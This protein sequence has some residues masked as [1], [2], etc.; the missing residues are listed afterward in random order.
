MRDFIIPL[1]IGLAILASA[2]DTACADPPR[3]PSVTCTGGGLREHPKFTQTSPGGAEYNFS[4][5][6]TTREGRFL[7]YRIDG[8]WTPSETA[9]ANA[10]A[11]EVYHVETLSGPSESFIA[12]V[13]WRCSIDPWLHDVACARIGNNVPDELRALWEEIGQGDWPPSSRGIPRN[14]RATLIT[15]YERANG[16]LARSQQLT[17]AASVDRYPAAR[18]QQGNRVVRSTEAVALNPQPLPPGPDPDVVSTHPAAKPA[19]PGTKSAIIIVGGKPEH[20]RV[21]QANPRKPED[22]SQP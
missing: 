10:N 14:E 8:T 5:V 11:S 20:R 13:G 15:E 16:R 7:G 2:A 9:G 4:G 21:Q 12:I 3:T 18:A 19:I 22:G 1:M 17:A 6:C